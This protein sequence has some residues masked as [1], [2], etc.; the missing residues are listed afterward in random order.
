MKKNFTLIELLVVIAIIAILAAL[1]LPALQKA[2]E[3]GKATSCVNNL[4][5][6]GSVFLQYSMD[7]RGYMPV[8]L[9]YNRNNVTN[10]GRTA[11]LECLK[12]SGYIASVHGSNLC[13]EHA[14]VETYKQGALFLCCPSSPGPV[15][16]AAPLGGYYD[17]GGGKG[18]TD[19]GANYYTA[20]STGNGFVIN[21]N[22]I[23]SPSYRIMLADSSDLVFSSASD[24]SSSKLSV[25]SKRHSKTANLT[26]V[27]GSVRNDHFRDTS[28]VRYGFNHN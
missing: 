1:L 6:L 16:T 11:W 9:N 4:K 20:D 2:R 10:Y 14:K 23:V 13:Y 22:K 24:Y 28:I 7:S 27:D 5:T 18:C 3:R 12:A 8:P 21:L 19:Y 26:T 17:L 15:S 25:V